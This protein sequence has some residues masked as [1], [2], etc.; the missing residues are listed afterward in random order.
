[1]PRTPMILALCA[2]A[3]G[4]CSD[5][6]EKP[7]A[8]A[9]AAPTPLPAFVEL[10]QPAIGEVGKICT[11]RPRKEPV[12]MAYRDRTGG[13]FEGEIRLRDVAMFDSKL[14]SASDRRIAS[15]VARPNVN[16]FRVKVD[17]NCY[18]AA[19]RTYRACTKVLEAN[20][21]EVRG[22]ARGVLMADARTLAVQVCERKVAELVEKNLEVKQDNFDMK[23]HVIEQAWCEPPPAPPPPPTTL[24]KKK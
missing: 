24:K 6:K 9:P 19:T 13:A 2:M 23:C 16:T 8:A 4:A 11:Y 5:D 10:D 3:L 12:I 20:V 21:K 18:D 14:I 17:D 22:F 1:M 15:A 7:V